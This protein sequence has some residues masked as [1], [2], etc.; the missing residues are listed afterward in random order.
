MGKRELLLIVAF[1]IVGSRR[2]SGHRAAAGPWR[3]QLLARARSSSRS[4]AKSAATAPR[5]KMTTTSTHPLDAGVTELRIVVRTRRDHRSPARTARDIAAELQVHSNG[6]DEAEAAAAGRGDGAQDRPGRQPADRRAVEFPRP[7]QPA[8]QAASEDPVAP[9]GHARTRAPQPRRHQRRRRRAHELARRS[10]IERSPAGC[11]API[12]AARLRITDSGSVE[13]HD[14][15]QRRAGR[16]DHG[17]GLAQHARRG[18]ERQRARRRRSTSTRTAPTSSLEKLEKTTGIVRI[19][20]VQG[21]VTVKGLR[22]EGRI[23]VRERR[24]GR[25]RRSR[26]AARDLQRRRRHVELTPPA[27]RLSARRRRENAERDPRRR[28]VRVVND[29][30]GTPRHR[31]SQRRRADDH[32]PDRA[33]HHH[34]AREMT[35]RSTIAD[36]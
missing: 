6:Y 15:R 12:G 17:R 13:A 3:A 18:P 7:G 21:S 36:C 10:E 5:P 30:R 33:R 19:N 26:G 34:G 35:A 11:P 2:L 4:G 24:R 8:R 29:R 28:P 1:V 27:G 16:T 25:G 14:G 31:R 23:D 22:T 9:P 32:D 20:A